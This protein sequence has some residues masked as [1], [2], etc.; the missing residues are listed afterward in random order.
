MPNDRAVSVSALAVSDNV[1]YPEHPKTFD[2]E[3]TCRAGSGDERILRISCTC[4]KV[5]TDI[6]QNASLLGATYVQQN[7]T[8]WPE[9]VHRYR[10][11]PRV[12]D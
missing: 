7:F 10:A 11:V 2:L 4:F 1:K 9:G 3:R 5:A 8:Q 12:A 6:G